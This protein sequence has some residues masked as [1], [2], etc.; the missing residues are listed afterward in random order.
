MGGGIIREEQWRY[1]SCQLLKTCLTCLRV[2]VTCS[3]PDALL[4]ASL[5]VFY[6]PS[7]ATLLCV[8]NPL[9]CWW[10]LPWQPI[11]LSTKFP[12][13]SQ[14]I[15]L[16]LLSYHSTQYSWVGWIVGKIKSLNDQL[17]YKIA[18]DRARWGAHRKIKI[19]HKKVVL[20]NHPRSWFNAERCRCLFLQ[21]T[22]TY[23][24]H[25]AK[26]RL[27]DIQRAKRSSWVTVAAATNHC[28]ITNTAAIFYRET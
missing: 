26:L 24:L 19:M 3:H 15:V 17:C 10:L 7:F 4:A 6:I 9:P 21:C 5:H 12:F 2:S 14:W 27:S 16:S 23:R 18:Q 20:K 11:S 25:R 13:L 8:T 28:C 22:V 1:D